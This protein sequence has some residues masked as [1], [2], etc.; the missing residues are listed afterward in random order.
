[1]KPGKITNPQSL[2][3]T[4]LRAASAILGLD[5]LAHGLL[6]PWLGFYWDDLPKS[7]F[8]HLFGPMGFWQAYRVDR[9]FLP[10]I[11][12][13]TTPVIGESILG[14]QVLGLLARGGAA[15]AVWWLMHLTWP[16]RQTL[17]LLTALF[18][19]V[20]PGFLQGP[21]SLIY[22]HYF[23]L[24][25]LFLA[26]MSFSV[27][28]LQDASRRRLWVALGLIA[29]ALTLFSFEYLVGLELI[30]PVVFGLLLWQRGN[31]GWALVR[32][33]AWNWLPYAAVLTLYVL[34]RTWIVSFPTYEPEL[35][36]R[37]GDGSALGL[38][39]LVARVA[40]DLALATAGAWVQAARVPDLSSLGRLGVAAMALAGGGAVAVALWRLHPREVR[41]GDPSE[42]ERRQHLRQALL[43]GLWSVLVAGIPVWVPLLTVRLEFP[44]DRFT[45]AFMLGSSMLAAASVLL[46][47]R[48]RALAIGV[49]ALL[50]G[51]GAAFHAANAVSYVRDWD[52]VR[53]FLAQLTERIP[54]L[55]P[56][57]MLLTNSI[58]FRY[59][60][61]NSLS[62]PVNWAYAAG[63]EGSRMPYLVVSVPVRLGGSLASLEPGTRLAVDYRATRFDG[64]TSQAIV[65]HY[66]PYD[67]L[68][69]L[70]PELHAGLPTL[71]DELFEALP[72]S[73][74]D[75]IDTD[76]D[77][78]ARSPFPA[79]G[80]D[81]WCMTFQQA[82]LARQRG[83]WRLVVALGDQALNGPHQ[84]NHGSEYIPFI[85]GYARLGRW[86]QALE[87]SRV[88]LGRDP[89]IAEMLCRAWGRIEKAVGPD[90]AARRGIES[91]RAIA[92]CEP[93][94]P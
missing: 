44:R 77:P 92:G 87:W 34:W 70:D 36:E 45:F 1:M 84:P 57:T 14:W 64:S 93:A 88:A 9:P 30:R 5:V 33:T 60:T 27:L 22:S 12:M 42:P 19:V 47:A 68:Q 7:W 2:S 31:R 75:L 72:L 94:A 10:W 59:S 65:V 18:F 49:A 37:L 23:L 69:V 25:G 62:A 78:R 4:G 66:E 17:A 41:T 54:G 16:R 21:I 91:A 86:E 61:D 20:Y 38:G 13:L 26:S 90:A 40:Q 11:Y 76:A 89:E 63:L 52:A 71:S 67:C 39:G 51:L 83:D 85:E 28:A 3:R 53:S 81:E 6:I 74:L 46:A 58:P 55:E 32:R 50:L 29:L 79:P 80:R 48:R 15:L 56:G 73:R 43:L 82:D 8:L 35:L 24:F